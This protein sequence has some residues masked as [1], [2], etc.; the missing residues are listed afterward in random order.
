MLISDDSLLRRR[1]GVEVIG[2]ALVAKASGTGHRRVAERLGLPVSTVRGWLR[3]F[4]RNAEMVRVWFTVLAHDLDPLLAAIKPTATVVGD[5]VEAIGVAARAS[6]LRLGPVGA[7][8]FASSASRGR[9]LS[10]TGWPW[11]P[12]G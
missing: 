8:S 7:W 9:L 1:D 3:R 6:V 10:N 11:A 5:A 12:A 2:A 4:A